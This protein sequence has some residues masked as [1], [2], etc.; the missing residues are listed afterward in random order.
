MYAS[1]EHVYLRFGDPSCIG[2]E[3]SSGK[4]KWRYKP[5]PSTAVSVGNRV[6]GA[7]SSEGFLVT[8]SAQSIKSDVLSGL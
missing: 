3:T 7:T 5:Y 1:V 6:V 4:N 8:F 2:F